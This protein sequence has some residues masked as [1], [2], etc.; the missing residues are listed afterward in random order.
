MEKKQLTKEQKK[1]LAKLAGQ[2][3]VRS[4]LCGAKYGLILFVVNLIVAIINVKFVQS[5]GFVIFMTI[6]NAL[7][8]FPH[9]SREINQNTTITREEIK[10]VL[11]S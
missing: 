7:M 6:V 2:S 3:L 4:L 5:E 10:K 1:A 9:M 8:V 11:E